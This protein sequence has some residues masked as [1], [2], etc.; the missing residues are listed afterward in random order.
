MPENT[1]YE[2]YPNPTDIKINKF[3]KWLFL[4]ASSHLLES[5]LKTRLNAI[6][7]AIPNEKMAPISETQPKVPP[8][9]SFSAAIAVKDNK[10]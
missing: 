8:G 7:P 6:F 9:S 1:W 2:K 4:Q 5:R 10:R 3:D